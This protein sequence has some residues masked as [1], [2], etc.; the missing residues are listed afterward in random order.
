MGLLSFPKFAV[1]GIKASVLA[2]AIIAFMLWHFLA[3]RIL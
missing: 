2:L 1:A 3:L